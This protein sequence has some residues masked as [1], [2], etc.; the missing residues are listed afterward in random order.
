MNW[1]TAAAFTAAYLSL[2][3]VAYSYDLNRR[4]HR[5]QWRREQE[6]PIVA[7]GLTISAGALG[8]WWKTSV[9]LD[10][11]K[12]G[13]RWEASASESWAKG[14]ALVQELR[15]EVDPG[16]TTGR[17]GQVIIGDK[18]YYGHD[19]EAI[20]AGTG[21][22]LLRPARKGE[23]E[24]Q[25]TEFFRPLRQIIESIN[26]TLKGQL[27]LERHG[28]RT[29]AGV[30]IRVLQRILALTATIWHNDHAGQPV[31]RSL[32]AYDH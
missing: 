17:N 1:A 7:R 15:F 24:R 11:M 23:A 19:F 31:A 28:G 13:D 4:G 6:R 2:V 32:L 9:A 29:P 21:L 14:S 10:E 8:A 18:N 27:D 12:A 25:G 16:L 3:N 30:L 22:S 5:E 20:L 26:D